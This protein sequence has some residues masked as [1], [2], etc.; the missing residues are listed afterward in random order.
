MITEYE[1][2]RMVNR[3]MARLLFDL[4]SANCQRIFVEAVKDE[5]QWL[6]K[7]LLDA[8]AREK[9]VAPDADKN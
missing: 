3:H 5:M 8:L 1:I 4:E 9:D 6:R 2:I 7:D